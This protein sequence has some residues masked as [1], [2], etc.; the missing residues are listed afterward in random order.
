[1]DA[2][3]HTIA[4][5]TQAADAMDVLR[6]V[7]VVVAVVAAVLWL[8]DM[9]QRKK[10]EKAEQELSA[11]VERMTEALEEASRL[12]GNEVKNAMRK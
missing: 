10:I 4:R 11:A 2:F 3:V 9:R 1:M 8:R 5:H 7:F 6:G 12:S